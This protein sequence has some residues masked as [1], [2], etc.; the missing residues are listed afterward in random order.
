MK[1]RDQKM[2]PSLSISIGGPPFVLFSDAMSLPHFQVAL[3]RTWGRVKLK[4]NLVL[5]PAAILSLSIS[6]SSFYQDALVRVK[7]IM[8]DVGKVERVDVQGNNG[9]GPPL[10]D[11][12]GRRR[13]LVYPLILRDS[14][15]FGFIR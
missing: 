2:V 9:D 5:R 3:S 6:L 13:K 7:R 12:L 1:K 8:G 14:F 10:N 11:S 4:S 15:R